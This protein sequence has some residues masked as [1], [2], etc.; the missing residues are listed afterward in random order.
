MGLL[1]HVP[2][3][4]YLIS[5]VVCAVNG[6]KFRLHAKHFAEKLS[7]PTR[8]NADEQTT[9]LLKHNDRLKFVFCLT[10]PAFVEV[11]NIAYS[12]DGG[13]DGIAVL[14]D[15]QKIGFVENKVTGTAGAG[16]N[17]FDSTGPIGKKQKLEPGRH[18]VTVHVEYADI[19]GLEIDYIELYVGDANLNMETFS[20]NVL[21]FGDIKFNQ[22]HGRDWVGSA[23]LEQ[24]SQMSQCTE[25]SNIKIPFYHS[26]IKKFS[27]EAMHPQYKTHFHNREPNFTNCELGVVWKFKNFSHP[28]PTGYFG[29]SKAIMT[30]DKNDD[31]NILV[32]YFSTDGPR[33]GL[34]ES[35]IGSNL[36]MQ[37]KS[38][39]EPLSVGYTYYGRYKNWSLVEYVTFTPDRLNHTWAIPDYSWV[40]TPENII[41]FLFPLNLTMPIEV[42]EISLKSKNTQEDTVFKIF[43]NSE[44]VIEGVNID[45]FW[46]SDG[47]MTIRI[48]DSGEVYAHA[49]YFR[50]G[51]HLPWGSTTY[52]QV[53]VLYRDG[54][55]R[56]LPLAPPGMDWIPFGSSL[57]I[58][59]ADPLEERPYSHISDVEID[60]RT[61]HLYLTYADGN[62]ATIELKVGFDSTKIIVKDINFGKSYTQPFLIYSSM[63]TSDG[64]SNVDHVVING[65]APRRIMS[66]WSELYGTSVVF[67]RQCLSNHNTL[68]PDIRVELLDEA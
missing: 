33:V 56:I 34:V 48:K 38:L 20:C 2:C 42:D 30:E 23:R 54:H 61:N 62:T 59:N 22:T 55:I 40:E 24:S 57:L 36:F 53:F 60:M 31:H 10:D 27:V 68:S 32:T 51:T 9:V 29:M 5:V 3:V 11:T 44:K 41:R 52:S 4:I 65:N 35:E 66:G 15:W 58:G 7:T 1:K 16:W 45:F 13:K 46:R 47:N 25:E 21:C 19:Y 63:W 8:T 6:S 39:T 67:Y 50:I 28:F 49:D 18:I 17:M 26:S 37:L 12:N 43:D 14:M 64:N